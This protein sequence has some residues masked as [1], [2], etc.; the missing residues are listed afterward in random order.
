MTLTVTTIAVVP[1]A[2][3]ATSNTAMEFPSTTQSIPSATAAVAVSSSSGA[4]C[5]AQLYT[6]PTTDAACAV[7]NKANA[8]YNT[9][10]TH[11][12]NSA[13]V[14]SYDNNCGLYCL[15]QGQAVGTLVNC[16]TGAGVGWSD[17]FCNTNMTA[18]ATGTSSGASSTSGGFKV[19]TDAAKSGAGSVVRR[20]WASKKATWGI[21]ALI[22]CGMGTGPLG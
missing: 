18:T 19:S 17:V 1:A 8:N 10:M 3:V 22:I 14:T 2:T 15:A 13:A 16:L 21:A 4:A 6:I 12:C 20:G 11:C 7:P 9:F 5:G